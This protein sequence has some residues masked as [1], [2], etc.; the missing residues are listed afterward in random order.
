VADVASAFDA[1]LHRGTTGETYN[2]GTDRERTVLDV[3]RDILKALGIDEVE[4]EERAGGAGGGAA[5]AAANGG[6]GGG[7]GGGEK[8]ASSD[9]TNSKAPPH[10]KPRA[11][12]SHVRDRAFNDRR[13]Y[14]GS[15]KLAALG[16]KEEISWEEGLRRTIEWYLGTEGI[17]SYWQGDLESALRPHPVLGVGGALTASAGGGGGEPGAFAG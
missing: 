7:S 5:V 4:G 1:V 17:E 2:V 9:A 13:Y 3:A 8:E 10:R 12:I 15:E 14:I 6:N 16:W 11:R